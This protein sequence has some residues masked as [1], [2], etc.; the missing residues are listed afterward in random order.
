MTKALDLSFSA[1][2]LTT[3]WCAARIA[4]GY[5]LLIV[6]LWT[7]RLAIPHAD[8]ALRLWREAGGRTQA[9]FAVNGSRQPAFHVTKAVMA[10]GDEWKHL[11]RV[12][13][14]VEVE[15]T[16]VEQIRGA[17]ALVR[18]AGKETGIYS[19]HWF[20]VG[21]LGNPTDFADETLWNAFYDQDPDLDFDNLPFGGWTPDKVLMEQFQ[22]TTNIEGIEVDLNV[23]FVDTGLAKL[24]LALVRA[25][26]A[27]EALEKV[28]LWE[29]VK[30][31][32]DLV[33][34]VKE[35]NSLQ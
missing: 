9:Y 28:V 1:Q 4:E 5:E 17:L 25:W 15:G 33:T 19:A 21:H 22:G 34:V 32:V 24:E 27:K 8:R 10:A 12:W 7:A 14:D 6:D 18:E 30:P 23:E 35:V 31:I 13:V 3:E 29:Y 16:L 2:D 11:E 20:W 26:K